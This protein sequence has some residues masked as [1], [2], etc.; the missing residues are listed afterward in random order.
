MHPHQLLVHGAW[1]KLP[2]PSRGPEIHPVHSLLHRNAR[3]RST[4]YPVWWAFLIS[5]F[6][7]GGSGSPAAAWSDMLAR[8]A[9][10]RGQADLPPW[11]V[12]VRGRQSVFHNPPDDTGAPLSLRTTEGSGSYLLFIA[13]HQMTVMSWR[14][15]RGSWLQ[16]RRV[17]VLNLCC[18]VA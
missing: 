5:R 1:M 17:L 9:N 14:G 8:H 13:Q 10:L 11:T 12:W 16:L 4:C 2:V 6:S 15:G 18:C 7:K 3:E